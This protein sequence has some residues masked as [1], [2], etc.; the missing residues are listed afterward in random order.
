MSPTSSRGPGVI[1]VLGTMVEALKFRFPI[2]EDEKDEKRIS[3]GKFSF[4]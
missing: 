4:Q 1:K 3:V 2:H